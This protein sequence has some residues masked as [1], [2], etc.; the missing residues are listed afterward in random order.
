MGGMLLMIVGLAGIVFDWGTVG[1][2]FA[3]FCAAIGAIAMLCSMGVYFAA[4]MLSTSATVVQCPEC[5]RMTKM[6]GK[7][8]RCMYCKTILSLDPKHA[9]K[10]SGDAPAPPAGDAGIEANTAHTPR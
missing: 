10:D 8:D 7:T 1:R 6:L 3:V 2:W 4:G 9:P 5:D